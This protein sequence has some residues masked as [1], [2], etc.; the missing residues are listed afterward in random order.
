MGLSSNILWHQ[1]KYQYLTKILHEKK[2]RFSYSLERCFSMYHE[3]GL[4][5]PM[6]SM[7]DFPFSEITV[8][9]GKYGNSILG[10]SRN[11]GIKNGFCPVWYCF[12]DSEIITFLHKYYEKLIREGKDAYHG[13]LLHLL[14]YMKPVES[15]LKSYRYKNYRFYDEREIR[16]VPQWDKTV[17]QDGT[18][19]ILLPEDYN[20]YKEKH[21]NS[22]LNIGVDFDW[23][24]IKYIVVDKVT[25]VKK[26]RELLEKLGCTNENIMIFDSV[27]IKED[28]IGVN[29]NIKYPEETM[30]ENL[31][32]KDLKDVIAKILE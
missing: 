31:L 23:G 27:Q 13:M 22:L 10:L 2:L 14:S 19:P 4:A 24:D 5:F 15:E 32:G 21:G 26:M 11:W 25:Q 30:P 6:V 7:C 29:H 9:M 17:F 18:I 1:T 16:L 20:K 12:D 28:F 8:Y 3:N